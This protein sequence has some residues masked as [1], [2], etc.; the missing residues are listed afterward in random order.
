LISR[1]SRTSVTAATAFG[2]VLDGL[3][4]RSQR[5]GRSST[6]R[7]GRPMDDASTPRS[8]T[9]APFIVDMW[10]AASKRNDARGGALER[11]RCTAAVHF[12]VLPFEIGARLVSFARFVCSSAAIMLKASTGE[13]SSSPVSAST[14]IEVP[15]PIAP[16]SAAAEPVG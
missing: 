5:P 2:F 3:D 4:Q 14:R 10:P 7:A 16:P 8:R 13:P 1:P 15:A 9:A 12:R 6:S 11:S